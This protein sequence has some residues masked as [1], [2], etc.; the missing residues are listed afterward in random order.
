MSGNIISVDNNVDEHFCRKKN[1]VGFH[2]I[3]GN[4]KKINK[5]QKTLTF[6]PLFIL[7][8]NALSLVARH[9]IG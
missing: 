9:L 2:M 4:E 8:Y 1:G 5:Q 3:H 7:N 6:F